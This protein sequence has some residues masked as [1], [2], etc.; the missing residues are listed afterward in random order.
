MLYHLDRRGLH[1]ARRHGHERMKGRE[2]G[3][4]APFSLGITLREKYSC[5]KQ[6]VGG[7]NGCVDGPKHDKDRGACW[8]FMASKKQVARKRAKDKKFSLLSGN[9]FFLLVTGI[10]INAL[11]A[12]A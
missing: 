11:S 3:A 8:L 5:R 2:E 1:A 6:D 9:N 4:K 7:L 10:R 12:Q